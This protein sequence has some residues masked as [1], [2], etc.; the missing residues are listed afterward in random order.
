MNSDP[1]AALEQRVRNHGADPFITWYDTASG[2]RVELSGITFANWVDKTVNL[3]VSLDVDEGCNVGLPLLLRYP[4]HWVSAVWVVA[5]WQLGGSVTARPHDRLDSAD[6]AVIG[7]RN[8]RPIP[9]V[10]TVAC[11]LHPLGVGFA[12]L[13]AG[14][15]DYAEVL[16]QPDLHWAAGREAHQPGLVGDD[17]T[18]THGSLA[19]LDPRSERRLI[20]GY[21]DPRQYCQRLASTL[22]GHGSW[23]LVTGEMDEVRRRQ[24]AA[25]ESA[26]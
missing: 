10:E 25:A 18:L 3:M 1:I 21:P 6:L 14:V 2:A 12:D 13:P 19:A 23:V 22:L 8:P 17:V 5:T 9:G 4:T 7:P 11:S 16:S 24:I 15:N 26:G 20:S